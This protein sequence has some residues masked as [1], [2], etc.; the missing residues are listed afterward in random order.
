MLIN[1]GYLR[2]YSP[3]EMIYLAAVFAEIIEQVQGS[4]I[5]QAEWAKG[6]QTFSEE[7]RQIGHAIYLL[8]KPYYPMSTE[9]T[10]AVY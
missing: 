10:V 3:K 1:D 5:W 4:G 7:I 6:Q 2:D 8:T 9:T